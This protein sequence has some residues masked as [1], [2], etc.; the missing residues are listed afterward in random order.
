MRLNFVLL[1]F[2][3]LPS[4]FGAVNGRCSSGNGVCV[5]TQSC[6][7]AGGSYVSGLC[8]NDPNNIKCCNKTRCVTS[9]GKVGSCKFTSN[10]SGTSYSG[11]CPG[12]TN[13]K[14]CVEENPSTGGSTTGSKIV[15]YA[16][17]FIGNPYVYGGN[18]LTKGIDCSGF[19]Q[20][21]FKHFGISLPRVSRDQATKGTAVSGLSNARAGDLT[22]YCTGGKVTHVA[23]YEGNN[24]IVHAANKRDGIKESKANYQTPCRIRRFI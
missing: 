3:A 19:T 21:V 15:S 12:G 18:S 20:Q 22:F 2:A 8:P 24:K 6:S 1:A 17:Q 9:E 11:L 16:R 10:C 13:F 23:I 14:C 7:K 4:V 5:S